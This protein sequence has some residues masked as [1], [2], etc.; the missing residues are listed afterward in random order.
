MWCR[1][2]YCQRF[3]SQE[4][5]NLLV[6]RKDESEISRLRM[7]EEWEYWN[8]GLYEKWEYS[9]AGPIEWECIFSSHLLKGGFW[10]FRDHF[11]PLPTILD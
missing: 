11:Y 7:Y 10:A 5:K 1:A 8:A 9:N 3:H 4:S 2:L 6:S